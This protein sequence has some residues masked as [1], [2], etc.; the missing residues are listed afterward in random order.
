[1][2]NIYTLLAT[3]LVA[4]CSNAQIDNPITRVRQMTPVAQTFQQLDGFS[5]LQLDAKFCKVSIQQA[6][7]SMQC[8]SVSGLIE[9]MDP[10]EGF[11]IVVE[12]QNQAVVMSIIIPQ[13]CKVAFNG[14]FVI[15]LKSALS[16]DVT[17]AAGTVV[18][19]GV[20]G[21]NVKCKSEFGKIRIDKS[22]GKFDAYTRGGT[23]TADRSKGDFNLV[24]GASSVSA[25]D[26]EGTLY[27]ESGEGTL[28]A[29]HI[30]GD[31][32]TTTI[33]GKQ[34][35]ENVE[36][37]LDLNSKSGAIRMQYITAGLI[38]AETVRGDISF[39]NSIKGQLN[40]KTVSGTITSAQGIILTDSSNFESETGRIK[41]KFANKKDELS[42]DVSSE[43]RD[44]VL[45]VK[46]TSKKKKLQVGSGKIVVTSHSK[47]GD[48]I[49]S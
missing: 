6:P 27:L 45:T 24:C 5:T 28:T 19:E 10:V 39:L 17:T 48:Q 46:G 21:C 3:L 13:D 34:S 30:K 7:D 33:S 36:G 15:Y 20:S 8:N 49:F 12:K 32:R 16:V 43:S 38:K 1:M 9:A 40:I 35:I 23:I 31:V 25:N 44:C 14:E 4:V 42:F 26:C 29:K 47:S 22:S 37:N 11:D 41:M 18:M 2:K